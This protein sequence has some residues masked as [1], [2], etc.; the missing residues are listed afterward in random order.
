MYSNTDS[1]FI[2]IFRII[3]ERERERTR[4]AMLKCWLYGKMHSDNSCS[5]FTK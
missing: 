5:L 1:V 4:A 3:R 2:S